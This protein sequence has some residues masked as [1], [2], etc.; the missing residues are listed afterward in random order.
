MLELV[1][2][3][4]WKARRE[5]RLN[6]ALRK[7]AIA[8]THFYFVAAWKFVRHLNHDQS[9]TPFTG[10]MHLAY[11]ERELYVRIIGSLSVPQNLTSG[12]VNS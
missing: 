2:N 4:L 8:S 9:H 11:M 5:M 7:A 10:S 3:K 6:I 12:R 1:H